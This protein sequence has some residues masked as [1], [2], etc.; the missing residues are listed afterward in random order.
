[1]NKLTDVTTFGAEHWIY[2]RQHLAPHLTGWCTVDI[3]DKIGLGIYGVDNRDLAYEKCRN[4]G[5]HI[6]DNHKSAISKYS[7]VFLR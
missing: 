4:W 2:C 5:L 1:M 7:G 3:A 6:H